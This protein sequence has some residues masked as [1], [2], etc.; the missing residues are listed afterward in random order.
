[1][2]VVSMRYTAIAA[3]FRLCCAYY[4]FAGAKLPDLSG[5]LVMTSLL[6][7]AVNMLC[8]S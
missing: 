5:L 6:S 8:Y 1:V 3:S 7:G 2:R 4:N